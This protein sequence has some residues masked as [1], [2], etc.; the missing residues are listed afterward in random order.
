M[1][2]NPQVPPDTPTVVWLEDLWDYSYCDLKL[3]WK[4]QRPAPAAGDS[5]GPD[6]LSGEDLFQESMRQSLNLY[7]RSRDLS[8]PISYSDA[9]DFVWN[10]WMQ[11]WG[12]E[13]LRNSLADFRNR[14]RRLLDSFSASGGIRR[15]DN[16]LYSRPTWTN[17]WQEMAHAGGLYDLR[18]KI[19]EA[20]TQIGLPTLDSYNDSDPA[21][22]IGLAE[23]YAI[24]AES[25]ERNQRLNPFPESA[26]GVHTVL[27]MDLLSIRL[28]MKAD[29]VLS[30]GTIRSRGRP[31]G[32]RTDETEGLIFEL[33][34]F[35]DTLAPP[36]S[37]SQDIRVLSMLEARPIDWPADRPF[38]V[39]S[40][41]IR[42]MR[43]G[44]VQPFSPRRG[45]SVNL[46]ETLIRGLLTAQSQGVFIPRC[47]HGWTACSDC[48]L[49]PRCFEGEG[50][51]T[52]ML[53]GSTDQLAHDQEAMAALLRILP[54][55]VSERKQLFPQYLSLLGWMAEKGIPPARLA[56]ALQNLEEGKP[57]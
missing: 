37:F 6:T 56:W 21:R 4:K 24:S 19:E 41:L 7:Y 26:H 14:Y 29:L 30:G 49:R 57:K 39:S 8:K 1:T 22:P 31:R 43:T 38:K 40:V 16:T 35:E 17:K 48:A 42:H 47:L 10:G 44:Q 54:S 18:K 2:N 9:V 27:V 3:W 53:P 51:L 15:P 20:H 36:Q 34:I 45:S 5:S 32:D 50:V 25:A 33:H 11:Q 52:R 28:Q 46:L 55:S 23:A 13:E 12:L